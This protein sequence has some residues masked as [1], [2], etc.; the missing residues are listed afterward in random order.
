MTLAAVQGYT[1]TIVD[2]RTTSAQTG[3]DMQVQ[4]DSAVTEE[5]ARAE[6]MLA[7]Q[8]AGGSITDI[9]SMTSVADIFTN[10]KGQNSLIRTWV[11]FDGHDDTLIWD[12]QAIPGDDIDSVVSA[13]SSGGFTAGESAREVLQD[14]ETGGEQVIEYTEYEF[15]LAPNF[16]MIVL[17]TVTESTVT[18]QGSHKWVP[19]LSSSEAEQA[20]VIGESSYRQLVGNSTA[21]SYTSTRWFFELCDQSNEDCADAL[22]AVSAEIANGNGVSAASDWSTAHRDNERNGGLIFGTPGLLS[23]QFIV[24]SLASVASAFVFLSLVLTQRKRELAILQAIGASPN[25]VMR[26]VLFEILSILTVSMALGV[27]LGLAIAESFNGFF[28][29]FGYIFQLFLGQSAP[30]ARELVWPW[31][32]LAIVNASVLAAVLIALFYTTRRALQA[33]LAVVLKGE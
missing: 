25:Q 20:I 17:T 5:Q 19:G 8:R 6:V 12:A 29:V 3:A 31:L 15:Q 27:V 24:A 9:D 23:L 13:W 1:G 30:I 11:L 33:D 7:I 16:E 26:L 4:F 10:P 28:G 2:E 21:D 22:R 32:D 14:L 18:Y